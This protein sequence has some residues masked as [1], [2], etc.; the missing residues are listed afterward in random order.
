MLNLSTCTFFMVAIT[1]CLVI[2]I[3]Y[4]IFYIY[5]LFLSWKTDINEFQRYLRGVLD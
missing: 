2:F 3:T 4:N 1:L 5:F